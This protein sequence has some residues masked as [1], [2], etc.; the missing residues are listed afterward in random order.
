MLRRTTAA[1]GFS[2][3]TIN[4][5][6]RRQQYQELTAILEHGADGKAKA[7]PKEHFGFTDAIGDPVFDGQYPDG[8]EQPSRSATAPSTAR[9]IGGRLRPANS[10]S[11]IPT[12]RKRS[13]APRCRSSFSRNGTFM[14]Y[15]KLHQNVIAFHDFMMK[16]AE[17]FGAVFGIEN[18]R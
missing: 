10:C 2:P 5:A 14:A 6:S 11:A 7:T 15:R 13:P 16:T 18:P 9:A 4:P 1:S 17:R 12:R 8:Y 3:V